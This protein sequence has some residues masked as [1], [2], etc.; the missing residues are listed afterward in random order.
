MYENLHGRLVSAILDADRALAN[1]L[2]DDWAME[3]IFEP[4]FTTK[5]KGIGLGLA[6]VKM[7]V[8]GHGGGIEVQTEEG[9]GSTFTVILPIGRKERERP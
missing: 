3:K 4:L 1:Q 7:L 6:L 9:K 5:T 2:I 8:E